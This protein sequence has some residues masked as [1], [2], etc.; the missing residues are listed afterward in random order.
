MASQSTFTLY[1]IK[2]VPVSLLLDAGKKLSED[3][4]IKNQDLVISISFGEISR[5]Q[6]QN[7]LFKQR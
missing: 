1:R 3:I 5:N 6:V 2:K 4:L 7:L